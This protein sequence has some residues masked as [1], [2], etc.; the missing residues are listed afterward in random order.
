M[1]KSF[2]KPLIAASALAVVF[3]A[4]A[5]DAG[6][7]SAKG[8][9]TFIK[10]EVQTGPIGGDLAKVK[11]GQQIEPGSV[12]KTGDSSRAELTFPDG[13]V[14]RIGPKSEL[15]I[16]G[17][18]FDK[19]TKAVGV[20]AE[21]TGGEAWAKVAQLVGKDAQF[22]MKTQNAVAGVR[23]T[24]FRVSED[25]EATLVKV[26][27]GSVAVAD[28]RDLAAESGPASPIAADRKEIAAPFAE[29][30]KEQFEHIL[31]KMMQVRVSKASGGVKAATP[32]QF[33]AQSD[34]ASEPDWVRW[35][36]ARDA[37]KDSER[38]D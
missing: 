7:P 11:R 26:Y 21:L 28:N 22:Q 9:V 37:G 13:S 5:T 30:S 38:S 12:V 24:V 6:T 33:D 36:S 8:K 18:S 15:K 32:T 2:L 4:S 19:K 16:E 27:N 10:G 23:G 31:G 1:T 14:V 20:Q 25:E 34:E 29:V 17:A 35:N 3:A